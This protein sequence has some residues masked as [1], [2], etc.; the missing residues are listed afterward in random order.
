MNFS[1]SPGLRTTAMRSCDSLIASSVPSRP[2]YFFR[3]A[4][5]S[6][7]RPG[8]SSPMATAT[9]PAPKSLHFF[10]IE[11]AAGFLNNLCNFLSVG[12]FPF[13]TSAPQLSRDSS[14][15]S[16]DDPVAP[17]Q[18]S[19]PVLPPTSTMMSPGSELSLFTFFLGAA[20]MTA[21]ISILF[22]LKSSS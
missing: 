16:L 3:T 5:R 12:G 18:P 14:V 10:I 8:A 20:A 7:D 6:M 2:S 17:P 21:P 11:L 15:C 19:L 4:S 1:T 22:A 9:P 13:C